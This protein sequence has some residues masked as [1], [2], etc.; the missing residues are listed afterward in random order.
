MGISGLSTLGDTAFFPLIELE[1]VYQWLDN[2]TFI[3]GSHTFKAGADFK[4]VQ[5]NFTQ[6]LGP[7]AGSFS[8]GPTFTSDPK[9]LATSGNSFADFL[10]GIPRFRQH[11]DELRSRRYSQHGVLRLFSRHLEG[12]SAADFELW[13]SL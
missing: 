3:R 9:N 5:P 12:E 11:C 10:L 1:N 13:R 8:F 6:I 4:K 2:L 7:P